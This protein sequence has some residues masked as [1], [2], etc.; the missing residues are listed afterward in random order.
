MKKVERIR[1]IVDKLFKESKI[2][3]VFGYIVDENGSVSP[4]AL[5]S[6]SGLVFDKNCVA[7]LPA[8]FKKFR[9]QRIGVVAKGCD[10]KCIIGLLQEKQ[11]DRSDVVIIAVECNGVEVDGK[12]MDK[13]KYCDVHTPDYYDYLVKGEG[14]KKNVTDSKIFDV[15]VKYDKMSQKEKLTFWKKEASKCIRCY[16]CRQACPMCYC[17]ECF[18]QQ[19]V[20]KYL[21]DGA[22]TIPNL[23]WLIM[24]AY[25]LAGRCTGCMEC[26]RVCP[27]GIPWHL[28]NKKM[29]KE[30]LDNFGYVAGKKENIGKKIPLADWHEE[31]PDK[32]IL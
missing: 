17:E 20:P 18:A 21:P 10:I 19:N 25:D 2:D 14:T 6:S 7:S 8:F 29:A 23:I 9:G 22:S 26:D 12:E 27:V 28:L 32:W 24:R 16:A 13:C 15:L 30:I 11:I 31:D 1:E 3:V 4:R 5:K